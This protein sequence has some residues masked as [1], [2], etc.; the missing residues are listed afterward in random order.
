M[1]RDSSIDA[2]RGLAITLVVLGHTIN[3]AAAV[4]HGGPGLVS[5]GASVWVP[6]ATAHN[7]LLSIAYSFHMPLM[8]YVSGLVM[9]PPRTQPLGEQIM[10]RVKTLLVPYFVWA[11]VLYVALREVGPPLQGGF[12]Q[13]M[14]DMLL[15]RATSG[16]WYLYAIFIC[17]VVLIVLTRMPGSRWT[18]PASAVLA[19]VASSGLVFRVPDALYLTGGVLWIHPFLVLGYL[20]APK[21]AEGGPTRRRWPL[22][23]GGA[24]AYVLLFGLRYPV[25]GGI[26]AGRLEQLAAWMHS[27]GLP[28]GHTLYTVLE[29]VLY[30]ANLLPYLCAFGAVVAL[31]ALYARRDGWLI[32]VQA[33]IGRRSL[34][35]YA[36]HSMVFWWAAWAGVHSAWWLFTLTLG[37]S[38]ALTA[39]L[40][41]IP[42][43]DALFFG[44]RGC[45]RR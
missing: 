34:G 40:E 23:V 30:R 18:V 39:F 2:L 22:V 25:F 26:G 14:L 13:M 36:L 6:T 28:G 1:K 11:V 31:D 33:W 41:R 15:G 8:A 24:T 38:L 43:I 10:R 20:A 32:D 12:G 17:T 7:P 3:A 19:I 45:T 44:Q 9:W 37:V 16:L 35:V 4:F 29:P 27:V 5:L 42:V 21:R